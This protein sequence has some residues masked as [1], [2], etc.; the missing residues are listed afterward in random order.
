MAETTPIETRKEKCRAGGKNAE[1][2]E[3]SLGVFPSFFVEETV[4]TGFRTIS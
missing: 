4:V 3:K 2:S 1:N